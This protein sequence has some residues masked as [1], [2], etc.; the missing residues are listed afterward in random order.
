M[1]EILCY[2]FLYISVFSYMYVCALFASVM[3][4]EDKTSL[5]PLGLDSQRGMSGCMS[6]RNQAQVLHENSEYSELLSQM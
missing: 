3:P 1:K 4:K 2:Y 5:S 6:A